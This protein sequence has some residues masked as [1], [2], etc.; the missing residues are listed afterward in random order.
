[1]NHGE[2]C[3]VNVNLALLAFVDGGI[4]FVNISARLVSVQGPLISPAKV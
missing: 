2:L 4:S 3:L 1:M